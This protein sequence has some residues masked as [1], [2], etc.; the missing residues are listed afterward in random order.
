LLAAEEQVG[1]G[2]R[3]GRLLLIHLMEQ[4]ISR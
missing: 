1:D 3:A 4:G 2:G